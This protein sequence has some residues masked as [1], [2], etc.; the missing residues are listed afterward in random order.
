MFTWLNFKIISFSAAYLVQFKPKTLIPVQKKSSDV[1][2]TIC[3]RENRN[4]DLEELEV[5]FSN[6]IVNFAVKMSSRSELADLLDYGLILDLLTPKQ[7]A[8]LNSFCI[9][10]RFMLKSEDLSFVAERLANDL[11]N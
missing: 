2:A 4:E 9:N 3:E 1:F 7:A 11:E 10:Q 8:Y 5:T 6:D